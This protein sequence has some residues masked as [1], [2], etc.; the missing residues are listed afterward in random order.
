MKR[1]S[2]ALLL[3]LTM[4]TGAAF[5]RNGGQPGPGPGAGPGAGAGPG[6][7][8]LLV[9]T[10]GTIF[11]MRTVADSATN[12]ATTTLTAITPSGSTAWTAT[13]TDRGRLILSG[14][15][16][17][18]VSEGETDGTSVITARSTSTGAAAWSVTLTG[19]VTDLEPFS[20]GTY[21]VVVIPPATEGGIPA[22]SLVAISSSGATLWTKSL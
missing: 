7:G 16:L 1:L 4:T 22:R 8:N 19:R 21:A 3:V 5:A 11:V 13:L 6:G 12:T 10:D 18:S 15:T 17:L 14:N 20:G 2:I 9:A